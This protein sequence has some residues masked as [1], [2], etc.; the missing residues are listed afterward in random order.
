M[1][2]NNPETP[3]ISQNAVTA[4]PDCLEIV[5]GGWGNVKSTIRQNH[6]ELAVTEAATLDLGEFTEVMVD[7]SDPGM[8]KVYVDGILW[9]GLPEWTQYVSRVA[10]MGISTGWGHDGVWLV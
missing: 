3:C 7:F 6:L 2:D 1:N 4:Y 5:L 10:K 8:G 9:L